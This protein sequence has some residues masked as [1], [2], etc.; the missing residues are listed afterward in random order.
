MSEA[1]EALKELDGQLGTVTFDAHDPGSV[2]AAI[3]SMNDMIETKLSRHSHNPVIGPLV[4]K[5][6]EKY[7]FAILEKAAETRLENG[8]ND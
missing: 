5:M 3:Q 7:R 1:S 4:E 6:K 8:S 2:E